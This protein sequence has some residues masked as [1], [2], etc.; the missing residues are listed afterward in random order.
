MKRKEKKTREQIIKG[1]NRREATA[2]AAS[3]GSQ[4]NS[5]TRL[6]LSIL[7]TSMSGLYS[8]YSDQESFKL[9]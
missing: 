9:L 7:C 8:L 4:L 3:L 1:T 2:A 5:G 6:Y